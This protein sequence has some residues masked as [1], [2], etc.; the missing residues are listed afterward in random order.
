MEVYDVSSINLSIFREQI[1]ILER[2]LGLLNK[3]CDN[4]S[5][6]SV[7][8]SQCHTLVEIGRARNISLKDLSSLLLLDM[9]T[10]SR[11]V[12]SLV[13]KELVERT[14]SKSD[15]RSV[16]IYLT[17]TGEEVFQDIEKRM[18][19]DFERIFSY[20]PDTEK[21]NVL[22]SLDLIISAFEKDSLK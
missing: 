11:T 3:N 17:P 13:K 5:C 21:Q 2:K 20:V 8:L 7:T 9:S 6:Q 10:T 19:L 14:T 1:R 15:R 16:D 4:K 12:E 18:N 22:K